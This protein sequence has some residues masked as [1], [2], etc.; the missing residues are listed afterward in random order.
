MLDKLLKEYIQKVRDNSQ[1][2][3][4]R[5]QNSIA[6]EQNESKTASQSWS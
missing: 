2:M 5:L 4:K 1:D 3:I 6:K